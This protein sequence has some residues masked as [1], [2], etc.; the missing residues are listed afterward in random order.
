MSQHNK[1]VLRER[2]DFRDKSKER[3]HRSIK[4]RDNDKIVLREKSNIRDRSKERSDCNKVCLSNTSDF[5]DH[6]KEREIFF[7]QIENLKNIIS[8]HEN[9]IIKL[10]FDILC[11]KLKTYNYEIRT[12]KI[13]KVCDHFLELMPDEI[14]AEQLKLTFKN[15]TQVSI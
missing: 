13:E 3:K 6:N 10:K 9:Q 4:K 8:E 1:I 2:S 7:S 15:T 14:M 12:K 11:E 5:I